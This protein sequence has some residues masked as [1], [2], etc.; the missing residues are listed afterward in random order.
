MAE[1]QQHRDNDR[2]AVL[3]RE[4]MTNSGGLG[5]IGMPGLTIGRSHTGGLFEGVG[6]ERLPE[7]ST[8]LT[9]HPQ[10]QHILAEFV[11]IK[12]FIAEYQFRRN[13]PLFTREP[14]AFVFHSNPEHS[15][16][17]T[18]IETKARHDSGVQPS[19]ADGD[20]TAAAETFAASLGLS[21]VLQ[22]TLRIV[23]E[24]MGSSLATLSVDQ[25][26]DPEEDFST[27]CFTITSR[28][29]VD[30]TLEC[31]RRLRETLA[32]KIPPEASLY[33]SFVYDFE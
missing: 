3:R 24:V 19:H 31:D 7:L 10:R 17:V 32:R 14:D 5:F 8:A 27:L 16:L 9:D 30:E 21:T 12:P 20:V 13:T 26:M 2:L 15:Q 25:K 18:I 11:A 1:L 4:F 23:R 22:E 28:S 29:S 6:S 33:L